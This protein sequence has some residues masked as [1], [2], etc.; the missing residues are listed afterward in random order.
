MTIQYRFSYASASKTLPT[1]YKKTNSDRLCNIDFIHN[2]LKNLTKEDRE[3]KIATDYPISIFIHIT[4]K[5]IPR[6]KTNICDRLSN[7]DFIHNTLKNLTKDRLSN[8]DFIHTTFK[9]HT[10]EEEEDKIATDYPISIF[11]HI[12]IK[13]HT[14]EEEEDKIAT[15]YPISMFI[16]IRLKNLTKEEEKDDK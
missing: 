11:A 5:T 2:T 8:V 4:L 10:K 14:K 7:I 3:D 16:R 1:K 15:D 9:N 12:T 6:K 13:N